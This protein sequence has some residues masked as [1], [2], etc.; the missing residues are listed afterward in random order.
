[1]TRRTK[2][3]KQR[4]ESKVDRS[5]GPDACHEWRGATDNRGYGQIR[6]GRRGTG[7]IRAHRLAYEMLHG[8]VP[9]GLFVCHHC[10]NPPCCNPGHLFAGTPHDNNMDMVAKG[11][12]GHGTPDNRGERHGMAKLNVEAVLEI[13]RLASDGFTE[14]EIAQRYGVTR[15]TIGRIARRE[16]WAHV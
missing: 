11:R 10:D 7:L 1:M 14:S 3:L 16:H 9:D 2:D 4:F 8:P 5:G 12:D 6:E 13:R 15:S